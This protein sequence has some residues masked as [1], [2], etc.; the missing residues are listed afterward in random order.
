MA[1]G[2]NLI[3]KLLC[4]KCLGLENREERPGNLNVAHKQQLR[5]EGVGRSAKDQVKMVQVK[6]PQMNALILDSSASH[7]P[8][9]C[10]ILEFVLRK[11]KSPMEYC[12]NSLL[13]CHLV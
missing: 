5:T 12:A 4:L 13:A 9:E 6:A 1:R 10:C 2:E 7:G 11:T 8:E 3:A